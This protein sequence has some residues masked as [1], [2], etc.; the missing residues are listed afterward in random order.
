MSNANYSAQASQ[1]PYQD[2]DISIEE[3][4]I[5]SKYN[6]SMTITTFFMIIQVS[7]ARRFCKIIH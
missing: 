2:F 6:Y 3:N 7:K 5:I 4:K 1:N